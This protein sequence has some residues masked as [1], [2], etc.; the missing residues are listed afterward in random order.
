MRKV[1]LLT[2]L[3][4][5]TACGSSSSPTPTGYIRVAN[6]APGV[7]AIDFCIAPTGGAYSTGVMAAAGS[8]EGI[9]YDVPAS[10]PVAGLKQMSKYFPYAAGTYSIKIKSNAPGGSCDNAVATVAS[11]TLTDG[12]YKTIAL[13]GITD[14]AGLT[15]LTANV[16]TD[17]V[18][19]VT[20]SVALRFV[21]GSLL[22]SPPG[23]TGI[24][25][26]GAALDI[27]YMAGTTYVKLFG[28]LAYPG[29]A[30]AIPGGVDA[31]GYLT[32]PSGNLP[33]A[34]T[35]TVCAAGVTPPNTLACRSVD[36]P[37]GS[38]KGGIV[39]SGYLIG[40]T[41]FATSVPSTPGALFCG[42]VTDGSTVVYFDNY[43]ACSSKL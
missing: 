13:Q 2:V 7:A 11:V 40:V 37:A 38:V 42:D 36:V 15:P 12:G 26:P 14:A 24:Y 8:T 41:S 5:F 6:L 3:A 25:T 23:A 27:G 22:F 10:T 20:T 34:L 17:E 32:I 31:N 21:N 35:L 28:N 39:A 43:S 33:A 18:S 1:A 30:A 4:L 16:F 9:I 19:V 29:T